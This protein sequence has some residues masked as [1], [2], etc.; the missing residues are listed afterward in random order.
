MRNQLVLNGSERSNTTAWDV[1]GNP[2]EPAELNDEFG[3]QEEQ[4]REQMIRNALD[5]RATTIIES[6]LPDHM[7]HGTYNNAHDLW[8]TLRTTYSTWGP[9]FVFAKLNEVMNYKIPDSPDPSGHIAHL[10]DLF[11]QI[12]DVGATLHKSLRVMMLLN[13]L[14]Q[15]LEYISSHIL[16]TKTE[17]FDLRL[18]DTWARIVAAWKNP[19]AVANAAKYRQQ[20]QQKPQWNQQCGSQLSGSG[21][22]P[23]GQ[24][25]QQQQQQPRQ[26]P[27]SGSGTSSGSGDDKKKHKRSRGK[28]KQKANAASVE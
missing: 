9:T 14:P 10:F 27:Q 5:L 19:H 3:T 20:N 25:Q 13:A 26:N 23:Q 17:I 22:K 2:T 28:G 7:I 21:L 16:A 24:G 12:V 1:S 11:S 6:A 15:R 8:D 18:E 4:T